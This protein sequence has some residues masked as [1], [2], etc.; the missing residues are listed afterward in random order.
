MQSGLSSMKRNFSC[1]RC[2]SLMILC[3]LA[4][5]LCIMSTYMSLSCFVSLSSLIGIQS[6]CRRLYLLLSICLL[7]FNNRVIY[8]Q[9][10]SSQWKHTIFNIRKCHHRN[11]EK[12][13]GR[14][15]QQFKMQYDIYCSPIK[16]LLKCI[17]C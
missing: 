8:Y 4:P 14:I 11:I 2:W 15:M 5:A 3:Y 13:Y 16:I 6:R 7:I 1:S 17:Q 9:P 12:Y 10:I